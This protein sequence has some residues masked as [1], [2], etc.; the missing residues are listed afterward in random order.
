MLPFSLTNSLNGLSVIYLLL[1]MVGVLSSMFF[2]SCKKEQQFFLVTPTKKNK[3]RYSRFINISGVTLLPCKLS[4]RVECHFSFVENGLCFDQC[5]FYLSK[6]LTR[7]EKKKLI[8]NKTRMITVKM[9]MQRK[10]FG[11]DLHSTALSAKI[12]KWQNNV[13][14]TTKINKSEP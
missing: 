6:L 4:N 14:T 7:W 9:K 8:K 12:E 5:C 10:Y 1:E 13:K 2:F 3:E 11:Q